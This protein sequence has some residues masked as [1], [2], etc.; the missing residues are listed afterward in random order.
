M[1]AILPP[2][3]KLGQGYV[4]TGMCDSVHG[5]C[6]PQ[7]MMGYHT[8]LGTGTPTP[9]S[10]HPPG[11]DTLGSR[12][13]PRSRHPL[14]ADIPPG[15]DTPRSRHPLRSRHTPWKLTPP[16]IRQPPRSRHPPGADSPL[17]ADTPP[18]A[19]PPTTEHA[20]RYGQCTGSTHP[21]GMQSCCFW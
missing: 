18:R 6:L 4:L 19:D 7:C 16:G 17:G 15:V 10:R 1:L 20:G 5:G 21:T 11:A 3:M 8:P 2:T 13:P 14:G 12:H 9:R